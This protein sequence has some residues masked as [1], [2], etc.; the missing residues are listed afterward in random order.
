M[1][2]GQLALM[3]AAFF[4]GAALYINVAEQP[5]RLAL[6]DKA[7]LKQWIPSYR[8]GFAMQAPLPAIGFLLGVL[9]WWQTGN[10]AWLLGATILV[11]NWPYTL[12]RIMPVNRRIEATLRDH[13]GTQSRTLIQQW[14]SLHAVRTALGLAATAA[15]F[16]ASMAF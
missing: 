11:V 10:L 5:A 7:L 8:R 9:A 2:A 14:G 13:A 6:D 16:W 1:L 3:T 12:L 4:A 15:F